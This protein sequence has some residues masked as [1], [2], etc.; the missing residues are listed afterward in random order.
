[1]VGEE[2]AEAE[3]S[4]LVFLSGKAWELKAPR[5][6]VVSM[7]L[8]V[9]FVVELDI[10][11][12]KIEQLYRTCDIPRPCCEGCKFKDM[13]DKITEAIKKSL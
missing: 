4:F 13:C 2:E 5:R 12:K 6:R 3:L 7:G 9:R 11:N 1:M 8:K 10:I